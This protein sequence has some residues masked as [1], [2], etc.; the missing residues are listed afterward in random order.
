M[1]RSKRKDTTTEP[2]QTKTMARMTKR[3]RITDR[4]GKLNARRRRLEQEAN[5]QRGRL[6][7][8][9]LSP[10][11]SQEEDTTTRIHNVAGLQ[12]MTDERNVLENSR[13]RRRRNF[14]S[15][16]RQQEA[17]EQRARLSGES[18]SPSSSQEQEE[19]PTIIQ[20]DDSETID[21]VTCTVLKLN[22]FFQTD[23]QTDI[24]ENCSIRIFRGSTHSPTS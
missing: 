20:N 11:S 10:P 12:A 9:S 7:E 1:A 4:Q 15:L 3:K 8:E 19:L 5:E 16:L 2:N 21:D 14:R 24:T 22:V 6:S 18:L 13:N 17:D 23:F